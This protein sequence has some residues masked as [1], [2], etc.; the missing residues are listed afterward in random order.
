MKQTSEH[1]DWKKVAAQLRCPGGEA[2]IETGKRMEES[3]T[4][5][6]HATIDVMAPQQG[7]HIMEIG[8]GNGAH[9]GYLLQKAGNITYAGIDMSEVMLHEAM[10]N[11]TGYMDN[12][13]VMLA[14][15]DGKNIPYETN[16]FDRIFTV[17][18]IYFWEN[19]VDY[20]TEI[21]R[22]LKPGGVL[23]VAFGDKDFM[24]HL[25][26]TAFGFNLYSVQ[27]VTDTLTSAG[28]GSCVPHTNEEVIRSNTGDTM[29][30][31]YH[32]V[33]AQAK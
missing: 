19:P 14:L 7:E 1:P 18:T 30:R 4:G 27:D 2:G 26:F 32:I 25:P 6:I 33:V 15:T 17:N 31:T 29:Q 24:Q 9:I 28:F 21:L 8:F 23:C 22:V 11:N 16:S 10:K 13:T 20:A 5:M 3:N 12:G